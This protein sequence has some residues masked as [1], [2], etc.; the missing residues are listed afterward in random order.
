MKKKPDKDSPFFQALQPLRK[1]LKKIDDEAR[2]R[3]KAGIAKARIEF[4]REKA[5]SR[6]PSDDELLV[7]AMAGVQPI[8]RSRSAVPSRK[9]KTGALV[10]G[11]GGGYGDEY[12]EDEEVLQE[13]RDLVDGKTRLDFSFSDEFV[14]GRARDCSFQELAKLKNGDF[15]V[16]AHCD[17]HGK[18][19]DEARESV[20]KFF[21]DAL[22]SSYR[23]V[24]VIS[25]R[26]LGS[27]GGK[28]VLKELLVRWL[29]QGQLSR[30]VLAFCSAQA[31]DGGVGALYVLLRRRPLAP[32]AP[33]GR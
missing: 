20:Q 26:G 12:G 23:C 18:N 27:P 21:D 13:L 31:H 1:E 22:K 2:A 32:A 29:V 7:R 16:Q 6:P 11:Y 15:A 30:Y 25:G 24:V 5:E 14:E 33:T 17:L 28:P 10:N 19:R 3:E 8:D 9:R 4:A